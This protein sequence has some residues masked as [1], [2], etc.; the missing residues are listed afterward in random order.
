[1]H[2]R[3]KKAGNIVFI[4]LLSLLPAIALGA[5]QLP[6]GLVIEETF[7]PGI[8]APVGRI[9]LVQ[10][11][12]IVMHARE[13]VGFRAK[14]DLPIFKKDTIMTLEKGRIRFELNDGSI[15]TLASETKMEINDSV[16]AP[17]KKSRFSFLSLAWGKARFWVKKIVDARRS[18]F[19]VRTRTAVVGVRGSDFVVRA[20]RDATRVIAFENTR[21]EL[22]S[23][24]RPDLKPVM[25]KDFE[26]VQ[27][28]LGEMPSSIERLSPAEINQV[29]RE[30]AF[31]PKIS[32]TGPKTIDRKKRTPAP[33][34]KP[35]APEDEKTDEIFVPEE[36][37]VD[38]DVMFDM[39]IPVE[40]ELLDIIETEEI[41]RLEERILEQQ[42]DIS[43]NIIEDAIEE[44]ALEQQELPSLPG[45]P[46]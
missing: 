27:V 45:T 4:F 12:V 23:M 6:E 18:E 13:K 2:K 34:E 37:L 43:E 39:E 15:L 46:E 40:P 32:P 41:I 24:A 9:Q 1:M 17:R 28:R 22:V 26:R 36:A 38:P 42:Q 7:K 3:Q 21:L 5:S 31:F 20:T 33:G 25:L 35:E 29:K 8:G 11:D 30:F 16:F 14:K 19:K 10:G 44:M